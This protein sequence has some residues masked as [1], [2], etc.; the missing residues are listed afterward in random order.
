MKGIVKM[1]SNTHKF[2]FLHRGKCAGSSIKKSLSSVGGLEVKLEKGHTNLGAMR[3]LIKEDGFDPEQ[4]FQFTCVRNPWDRVVSLYHHMST[5]S[6]RWPNDPEKQKMNFEGTFKEF[7]YHQELYPS[8]CPNFQ[9]FDHVVRYEFLQDDFNIL[10][11]KLDIPNKV[12]LPR[13]DYNT[14]RPKINYQSYYRGN[15]QQIVAEKYAKDIEYFG[16]KF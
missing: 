5:V 1:Y 3:K 8:I 2:I 7:L 6:K 10:C 9:D 12:E 15:L 4:Y 11:E 14:G 13:M 16:Y